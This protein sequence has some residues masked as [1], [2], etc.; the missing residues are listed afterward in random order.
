[1]VGFG[2]DEGREEGR[3]IPVLSLR[4]GSFSSAWEEYSEQLQATV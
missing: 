4:Y 1:L 3:Y 2:F